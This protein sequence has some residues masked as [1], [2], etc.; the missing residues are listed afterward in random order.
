MRKIGL[1]KL[2]FIILGLFTA[3]GTIE[4]QA[5]G[6]A[7]EVK[8]GVLYPL[9]GVAASSGAELRT[10]AEFAAELAN[11]VTPGIDLPM[12]QRGGI[13][14]LGGAK[15]KLIF[16][17]HE[18]NPT[19]GAD[20]AKKMILDDKVEVII[21]GWHSSVVKTV[22]AFCEQQGVPVFNDSSSS[23]SL[24]Q[25]GLK[26]FWRTQPHDEIF[27]RD[28][29][30]LLKGLTEGKVRGVNAIPKK[31]IVN[32][33]SACEKT[34]WGTFVSNLNESFAKEYGFQVKKALL[35][36]SKS[37]DFSSEVRSLQAAS[38]DVMIFASYTSDAILMVKTLRAQKVKP[39]ILLGQNAGF[40]TPEFLETL[41]QDVEG[42]LVRTVF[43]PKIAEA[44]KIAGQINGQ[45][46][47]KTGQDLTAGMARS[48][49]IVQ[50]VVDILERAG[51]AAP[52]DIQ[53]AANAT[54]IPGEMLLMPWAGIKFSASGNDLGQNFEGH[55]LI[56][57]YQ[58]N[59]A[60]KMVQEIVYPF[61]LAGTNMI[62]PFKGF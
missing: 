9:T 11:H 35:Y 59:K 30:E 5:I 6:A 1:F 25:R 58:K 4:S 53:K 2:G 50:T 51:S 16:K 24:T 28:H 38:P 7:Q 46:K 17:D 41:G 22:S 31:E 23:P 44:K 52:A 40:E 26:W 55:G 42:I 34:E 39:K 8:I 36:A 13:K 48:F 27:V 47:K 49:T 60:G 18:G 45:F 21:A 33:A 43:T 15:I 20:L 54:Y 37:A 14:S 19:L 3:A 32:M 12:A 62:Y 56:T 29:F 57:Q 10:G 61:N